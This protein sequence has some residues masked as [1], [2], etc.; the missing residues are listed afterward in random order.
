MLHVSTSNITYPLRRRARS[1]RLVNQYT[2]S[3]SLGPLLLPIR[4]GFL[5][6][7]LDL[8]SVNKAGISTQWDL[9][10]SS[11]RL[12]ISRGRRSYMLLSSRV[13]ANLR[14]WF[15][16]SLEKSNCGFILTTCFAKAS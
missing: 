1:S 4:F 5:T 15:I 13:E 11:I 3:Y 9:T 16:V 12:G 10:L 8:I 2:R 6:Q 7:T 14:A